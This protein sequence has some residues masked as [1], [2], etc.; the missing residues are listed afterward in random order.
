MQVE[1]IRTIAIDLSMREDI[2]E[3]YTYD[4]SQTIIDLIGPFWERVKGEALLNE[5]HFFKPPAISFVNFSAFKSKGNDVSKIR[6]DI[7][8]V[9]S[10]KNSSSHTMVCRT[11][12]GVRSTFPIRNKKGKLLGVLSMGKKID[13][14]PNRIK[15]SIGVDSFLI[16]EKSSIEHLAPDLNKDFMEGK[17]QSGPHILGKQTKSIPISKVKDIDFTKKIQDIELEGR[18]YSLSIIP[19]KDFTENNMGYLCLLNDLTPFRN[20]FMSKIFIEFTLLL[21]GLVFI[22]LYFRQE[23]RK[24][25]DKIKDIKYLTQELKEQNF[26]ILESVD[27][28][29]YTKDSL[30]Q[31]RKN[32]ISMGKSLQASHIDLKE[33]INE[34][35]AKNELQHKQLLHQNKFAQMGEMLEMIAHQWRQ[36]LAA[37]TSTVEGI[38]MML[39][40][41]GSVKKEFLENKI[42]KIVNYTLHLSQTIVDFRNF[43][44]EEKNSEQVYLADVVHDS[45]NIVEANLKYNNIEV[46]KKLDNKITLE[47]FPNAIKQV[48]INI[49]NNADDALVS[50][51]ISQPKITVETHYSNDGKIVL[52]IKDNAGG[53]PVDVMEHIFDPYFS[54][55]LDK[56]GT[57]IG[58]FMS[59][60][61]IEEHCQGSITV[62]NDT[63]GAVFTLTFNTTLTK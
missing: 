9:M 61:M 60:N 45:L 42:D 4:D 39:A 1:S 46:I 21:I 7:I 44:K 6:K 15:K 54:T 23:S 11:Y 35:V 38:R 14:L 51:A 24:T 48:V 27:D 13:W 22:Y 28:L 18:T 10:T 16:Y 56:D 43:L 53:I 19:I 41:E 2:I 50:M 62:H 36:P 57:G 3:A 59:K 8:W 33:R 63:Y 40:L 25:Y 12:A 34:A 29:P 20:N 32:V 37:I 52:T 58:L 17:L 47:T 55:K 5:I 31:L 49:I 30:E 26:T